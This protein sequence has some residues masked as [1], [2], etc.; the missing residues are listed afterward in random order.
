MERHILNQFKNKFLQMKE[1]L[2]SGELEGETVQGGDEAE[3]AGE[4]RERLLHVKLLGRRAFMLKKV[5]QA[6]ARIEDGSYGECRECGTDIA[7]ARLEARPTADYCIF[8][9]EEM[10]REENQM[11]YARRSHTHGQELLGSSNVVPLVREEAN[12]VVATTDDI[13]LGATSNS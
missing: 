11:L 12:R 5:D 7:L 6:L 13:Y 2:M 3:Q 4:E 8:C 1:E 10:E 9:K